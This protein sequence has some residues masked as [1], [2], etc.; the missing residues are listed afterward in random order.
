MRCRRCTRN[1]PYSNPFTR[2]PTLPN[3]GS[4]IRRRSVG[5]AGRLGINKSESVVESFSF[6][7]TCK[8]WLPSGCCVIRASTGAQGAAAPRRVH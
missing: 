8:V 1:D 7:Q 2:I 5:P 6:R 3:P 4:T